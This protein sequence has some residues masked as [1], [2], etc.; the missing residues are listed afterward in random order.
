MYYPFL[1]ARQF[2]LIALRELAIEGALQG[3]ITPVLEPVRKST[4]G[5]DLAFNIFRERK[6]PTYFVV[7]PSVGELPGD[8]EGFCDYLKEVDASCEIVQPA[9]H[10]LAG[11]SNNSRYIEGLIE[12]RGLT[13]C[14]LLLGKDIE[15]GDSGLEQLLKLPAISALNVLEPDRNRSLKR[16]LS[17]S[18]KLVIRFDDKFDAMPR[19]QDYLE[20]AERLFSEEH[21]YY[22]S[23]D[24][25]GFSDYTVLSDEFA[26]GGGAPRAVVIHLTYLKTPEQIWIRHFTSV[27]NDSI[28]NVQG[29]FNEAAAKAVQFCQQKLLS[30]SAIDELTRYFNEQRYPGLG[31]VKK[32]SIKNH[33]LVVGGYLRS[34]PI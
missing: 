20:V 34:A 4:S 14:M 33:L 29:K 17:K 23:D 9:F 19:N 6:T 7:N 12:S 26:E 30:N 31:T 28:A 21:A 27:T 5:L 24:F 25:D 22:K 16:N 8:K 32:I 18:G 11:R 13:N 10:Y 1:R 3:V 2:E 15:V